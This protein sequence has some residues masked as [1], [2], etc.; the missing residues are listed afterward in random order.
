MIP[1]PPLGGFRG[2]K[3]GKGVE[4]WAGKENNKIYH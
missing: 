4:I 3:M 2:S 1:S